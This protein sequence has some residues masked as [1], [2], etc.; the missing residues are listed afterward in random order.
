MNEKKVLEGFGLKRVIIIFGAILGAIIIYSIVVIISR[1]GKIEVQV[2][3]APNEAIVRID[4]GRVNNDGKYYLE[5]GTHHVEASF[6]NF[7]LYEDDVEITGETDTL[8]VVLTPANELGWEYYY[9]HIS[10]FSEIELQSS[11]AAGSKTAH[12]KEKFVLLSKLPIQD[13]YYTIDFETPS[14]EEDLD[15]IIPM[16]VVE[17]SLAYQQLAID[18]L[19]EEMGK[20]D[21]GVYDVRFERLTNIY[22]GKFRDNEARDPVEYIRN[23][24]SDVGFEF[25]IGSESLEVDDEDD[26]IGWAGADEELVG[27]EE[28]GGGEYG[29]YYYTYL[30]SYFDGYVSQVYRIVLTRDGDG[31]RLAGDPYPLLTTFNTPNVPLDVI[32]KVNSL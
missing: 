31:W 1:I 18:R 20:D 2:H 10:E 14:E 13:P 6:E 15:S 32:N 5:L 24:Y 8:F 19:L 21:F 9:N 29:D 11:A 26:E 4:G 12:L 30:R 27:D 22:E 28:T 17:S 16:I 7:E 25:E 3:C 23:G